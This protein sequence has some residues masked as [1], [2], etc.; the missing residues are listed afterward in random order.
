MV[1]VSF[2]SYR[3]PRRSHATTHSRASPGSKSSRRTAAGQ[4]GHDGIEDV[5]HAGDDGFK[6][7]GDAADDGHEAAAD[8][9]EDGCDL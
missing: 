4:A 7:G 3:R 1:L 9:A 2:P 6:D 5:D 8:G